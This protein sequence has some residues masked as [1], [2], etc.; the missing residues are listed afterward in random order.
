MAV[1]FLS[2]TI[3]RNKYKSYYITHYIIDICVHI[4]IQYDDMA[5]LYHSKSNTFDKGKYIFLKLKI[6]IAFDRYITSKRDYKK[7]H[8]T[9]LA[10]PTLVLS[11]ELPTRPT[12]MYVQ[13]LY[14]ILYHNHTNTHINPSRI[15]ANTYYVNIECE[16]LR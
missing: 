16:C 10:E 2:L 4:S 1:Q 9:L 7:S 14:S 13:F 5:T 11:V 6:M 3:S 8:V 12:Y 15:R